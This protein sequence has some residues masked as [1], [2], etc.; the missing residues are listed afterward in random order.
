MNILII[1]RNLIKARFFTNLILFLYC[2]TFTQLITIGVGSNLQFKDKM[3]E[4]SNAI[5][6]SLIYGVVSSA[7][8]LTS[9]IMS[10]FII[11]LRKSDFDNARIIS[12]SSIVN[13]ILTTSSLIANSVLTIMAFNF[14]KQDQTRNLSI[15][16]VWVV[17][18]LLGN[19]CYLEYRTCRELLIFNRR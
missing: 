14:L 1:Q 19:M 9:I 8:L 11:I 18:I 5:F 2:A 13:I 12:N 16:I 15:I 3:G 17:A 4:A 6:L 10:V 7:I